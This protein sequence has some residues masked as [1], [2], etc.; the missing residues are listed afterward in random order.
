MGLA[1]SWFDEHL[2]RF[3]LKPYAKPCIGTIGTSKCLDES[4]F[5]FGT[6][7]GSPWLHEPK[8]MLR[9]YGAAMAKLRELLSFALL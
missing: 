6:D 3:L 1:S 8:F 7:V 9:L 2:S 5:T 4:E